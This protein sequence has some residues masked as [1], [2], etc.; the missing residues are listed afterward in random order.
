MRVGRVSGRVE[1]S[2]DRLG[3]NLFQACAVEDG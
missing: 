2:L 3:N 1:A